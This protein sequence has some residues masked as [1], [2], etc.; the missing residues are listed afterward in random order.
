[1]LIFTKLKYI[2][3]K[4]LYEPH[5]ELINLTNLENDLKE[6]NTLIKHVNTKK[7]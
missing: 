6:I 5:I 2:F 3:L 4:Y 7:L 1:M